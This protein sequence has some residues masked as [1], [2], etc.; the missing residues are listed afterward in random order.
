[1]LLYNFLLI[2]TG[3]SR[4]FNG[5]VPQCCLQGGIGFQ[6]PDFMVMNQSR[7]ILITFSYIAST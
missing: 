7:T 1:M 2:A 3:Q 4:G 5:T 6:P